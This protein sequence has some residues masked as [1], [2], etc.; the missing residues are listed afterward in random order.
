ML[1]SENYEQF[2][3]KAEEQIEIADREMKQRAE[4]TLKTI[5]DNYRRLLSERIAHELGMIDGSEATGNFSAANHH[6][7]LAQVYRS[8]LERQ[9]TIA[10]TRQDIAK[11]ALRLLVPKNLHSFFVYR[12][13]GFEGTCS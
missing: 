9:P 10:A 11:L 5:A 3:R 12:I 4:A 7:A 6:R 8:M 13:K 1:N 2:L